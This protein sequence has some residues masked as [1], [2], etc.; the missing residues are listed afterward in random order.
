VICISKLKPILINYI[1]TMRIW[2]LLFLL[3]THSATYAAVVLSQGARNVKNG[4][5]YGGASAVGDGV[6]DDTQAFLDALNIGLDV[7]AHP[8]APIYVPPG[9][10]LVSKQLILWDPGFIFGEPSSPPT[11]ILKTGSITNTS[12]P[13][14]FVVTLCSQG[15]H[16]YDTNWNSAN[17][18]VHAST[19]NSF[20]FDIRDINF[21][22]QSGNPGVSAVFLWQLAQRVSARNIVLTRQDSVNNCWQQDNNG[23][24][25]IIQNMTCNG[26][27]TCALIQDT[28][29]MMY[30]GCTF[31]GPVRWNGYWIINFLAC[32]FN[33][34]GGTGFTYGGGTWFG[35]DD[36]VFTNGTPFNPGGAYHLEN[37]TLSTG[38]VVQFTQNNV[39]FNGGSI[40]GNSS[41][42]S[43]SGAV[44]G[45][46]FPNPAFPEP[47]GACVNVKSFGAKGDG[48][49]DDTAA[50]QK[51]YAAHPQVYFPPGTYKTSSTITLTAGQAMYG[52]GSGIFGFCFISGPSNPVINATGNG[53]GNGVI[54]ANIDVQNTA[55]SGS[56]VTWNADPASSQIL[57]CA[58]GQPNAGPADTPLIVFQT[59]GGLW[60]ESDGALGGSI[61]IDQCSSC[62]QSVTCAEFQS[63]GPTYVYAVDPEHFSGPTLVF[64]NA[65]NVYCKNV[66]FEFLTN[67]S[68]SQICQITGSDN[69]NIEG[70]IGG[71][72]SFQNLFTVS[73]STVNLFGV[74]ISG[75]SSG[76]V[77]EG[78]H[79][80][81]QTGSGNN[82]VHGY[83]DSNLS[84]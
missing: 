69:I 56:C 11:I 75:D 24:G 62:N 36:C 57:D 71:G 80:Y 77:G 32:T 34:P 55:P 60:D 72:H 12:S 54:M 63:S 19:N 16:P 66:Q 17:D 81:G 39:Y 23:G 5:P 41:V 84:P 4:A 42:L 1:I 30:R 22:V 65:Q 45:S 73:S 78:S 8:V 49:T 48:I 83:V 52:S 43:T 58:F 6:H 40:P 15:H 68:P 79:F 14:P 2:I 21:T 74:V 18:G 29:E 31:N 9:N 64:S 37:T 38:H 50:I 20:C 51:A 70:T 46:P 53:S 61:N 47:S 82:L 59:G 7:N 28:A 3:V 33:N 27:A 76:V 67:Q 44:K 10:Y 26:G 25:G 13:E 35:M